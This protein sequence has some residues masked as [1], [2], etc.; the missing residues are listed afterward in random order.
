ME[1]EGI[2]ISKDIYSIDKDYTHSE[3]HSSLIL[4]AV[5][6][7]IPFP[8]HSQYP[9][10]VFSSQQTKAAVGIHSSAYNTRFDTFSHI[11]HYPQKPIVTTRFKKYTDVDKLP[12]GVNAIVAIACYT[13]YNQEDAVILNKTSV[14]RG[15]FQSLYYRSYS[16]KEEKKENTNEEFGNPNYQRNIKKNTSMNFDKLDESGFV[17]EGEYVTADDAIIGKCN[18]MRTNEGEEITSIS[19]KTIKFSTSGIVD[20]VIV[21]EVKE[22]IRRCKIRIRK[23][24]VPGIGD[25]FASRCGQ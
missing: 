22:G 20:K 21:T 4:S 5:T 23:E 8:E 24:K 25:K 13:G 1:S 2:F 7:N 11:L 6:L 15:M 16:D 17:R 19:G 3:I 18:K 10:N 9:R 12:Y 14:E